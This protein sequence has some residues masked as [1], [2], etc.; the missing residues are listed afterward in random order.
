MLLGKLIEWKLNI[1]FQGRRVPRPSLTRAFAREIY[2]RFVPPDP[3][4]DV[5]IVPYVVI[6]RPES[7]RG[8]L[9]Q[10][11]TGGITDNQLYEGCVNEGVLV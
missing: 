11:L 6:F 8:T 7:G 5:G 3:P 4:D 2:S 1:S 9:V 10:G